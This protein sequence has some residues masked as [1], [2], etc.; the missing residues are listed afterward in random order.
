MIKFDLNQLNGIE[1]LLKNP[2]SSKN[3]GTNQ[4]NGWYYSTDPSTLKNKI[5]NNGVADYIEGGVTGDSLYVYINGQQKIIPIQIETSPNSQDHYDSTGSPKLG[6]IIVMP[7][8]PLGGGKTDFFWDFDNNWTLTKRA[9]IRLSIVN[10]AV[11]TH[12]FGHAFIA[13]NPDYDGHCNIPPFYNGPPPA[14]NT[15]TIMTPDN[16]KLPPP[17]V[18]DI[19]ASHIIYENTYLTGENINDI[20]GDNFLP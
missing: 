4:D 12:E 17:G 8:M 2:D 11:P 1:I 15:L 18:A 14:T 5:L 3:W 16:L 20:L 10:D 19:K 9:R 13:S 6:W 7:D